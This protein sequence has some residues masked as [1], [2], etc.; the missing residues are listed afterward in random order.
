MK[1]PDDLTE[2]DFFSEL[3]RASNSEIITPDEVLRSL[4]DMI[5]NYKTPPSV[6]AGAIKLYLDKFEIIKSYINNDNDDN[7]IEFVFTVVDPKNA[8]TD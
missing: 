1:K 4:S 7:D 3:E 5:R 8:D 6:R 2:S